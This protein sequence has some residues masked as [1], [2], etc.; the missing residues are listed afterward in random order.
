MRQEKLIRAAMSVFCK[1]PRYP[2][3]VIY[4]LH[5]E[6]TTY[7]RSAFLSSTHHLLT[8]PLFSFSLSRLNIVWMGLRWAT[9][10]STSSTGWTGRSWPWAWSIFCRPVCLLSTCTTTQIMP[11]CR[12]APTLLS[13]QPSCLFSKIKKNLMMRWISVRQFAQSWKTWKRHFFKRF[14]KKKII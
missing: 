2:F 7:M 14:T 11:H 8:V 1:V 5:T 10:P 3:T 13:G 9:V 6:C 12:W 4:V